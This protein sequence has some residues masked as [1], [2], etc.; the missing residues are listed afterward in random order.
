MNLLGLD[1]GF[2][3][4]PTVSQANLMPHAAL[5]RRQ[6]ISSRS[7]RLPSI[8]NQPQTLAVVDASL[9]FQ[10][11][12]AL[13][14]SEVSGT[15]LIHLGGQPEAAAQ[16]GQRLQRVDDGIETHGGARAILTLDTGAGTIEL[17]PNTL[18]R[19]KQMAVSPKGGYQTELFLERGQ[20][21]VK[22]KKFENPDSSLEIHTPAGVSGVRGTEF[23][24]TVQPS[25][26]TG[27]GTQ[28]GKVLV[29]G[30]DQSV[31]LPAGYQTLLRRGRTPE[32]V[33]TLSKLPQFRLRWL[34]RTQAGPIRIAGQIEPINL[35]LIN[36]VA[37][38]L[39]PQGRFDLLL[40]ISPQRSRFPIT[41]TVITPLGQQQ[42]YELAI[43]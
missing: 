15:V 32:S 3:G 37:H 38:P 39:D 1:L 25:G 8:V 21:K 19:I 5:E 29:T 33:A 41:I 35:L 40:P 36:Q 30:Q 2:I 34:T 26:D 6:D 16:P 9:R 11:V 24:M 14:V 20:A 23:G 7:F 43:P 28:E 27:I 31:E 12:R 4:K 10:V 18:L 22:V 13:E 17:A 42:R